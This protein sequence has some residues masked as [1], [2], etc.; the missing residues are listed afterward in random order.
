MLRLVITLYIS[1]ASGG[2]WSERRVHRK[3]KGLD[4]E[5]KSVLSKED[6]TETETK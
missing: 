4:S 6:G 2:P 1:I 5:V 3:E